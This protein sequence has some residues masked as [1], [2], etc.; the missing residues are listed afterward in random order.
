[1]SV[2]QFLT[3]GAADCPSALLSA[4]KALPKSRIAIAAAGGQ[5]PLESV[6]L[7]VS[8][9]LAEPILFGDLS[10]IEDMAGQVGLDASETTIV[11]A[12][13][14]VEA[15]NLAAQ[16]CGSGDAD[17]LMKGA[18]HTDVFMK[19]AVGRDN[20]LR[21]GSRFVH[22][23]AMY[24][25]GGDDPLLISDAAVNVAPDMAALQATLTNMIHV[26]HKLGVARPKIALLSATEH[27]I[28]SVPSSEVMAELQT[29]AEG[30]NL[31]ADVRGPLAL[32]LIFSSE[33]ARIK[34][35]ADDPVAGQAQGVVVPDLVSGNTLF[36]S[37]VYLSGAIAAGVIAGAKVP[38]LLTS[39]AD[40]PAARL[41][42]IALASL[43]RS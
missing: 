9:N 33:A 10:A 37:L 34:G 16:A 6:K 19:A 22:L 17:I 14:D 3:Q 15:A 20:G 23:F 27:P 5:L 13:N 40:P 1:M 26:W 42:S 11:P 12:K 7:A 24:P 31:S 21:T 43:L 38:I 18:L 36:K 4:A 28:P 30:E 32:D 39:R 29:W 25:A 41:A 2:T 8:E 35:L